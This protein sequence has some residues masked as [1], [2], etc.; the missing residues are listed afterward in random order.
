MHETVMLPEA[1][2]A[3]V[4]RENGYYVDGTFGRGG[5]SRAILKVLGV[6]GHLL[7]VDKDLQAEEV[8][9]SIEKSEPRF[10]FEQGSFALLPHQLR[11]KGID[12]IDGLLLDLGVSSPPLDDGSRGFSFSQD[13]PLD[14][15]MDTT[16]GAT[17]AQW[18]ATVK[19]GD[20]ARV[21][22]EYGEERYAG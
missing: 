2:A 19:H 12:A 20:L 22:R 8:A 7:A 4:T 16:T 18:L 14:M 5:H 3:L 15:R 11:R 1:V 6:G 17:A 21:L 10:E 9:R 13:G